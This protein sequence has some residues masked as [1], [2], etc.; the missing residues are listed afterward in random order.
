MQMP[1]D[2]WR[3]AH[4]RTRTGRN[5]MYMELQDGGV[6]GRHSLLQG[7]LH[8]RRSRPLGPC[9]DHCRQSR[10][11]KPLFPPNATT[12]KARATSR[13][14]AATSCKQRGTADQAP[15]FDHA[16]PRHRRRSRGQARRALR[17]R[18]LAKGRQVVL[19]VVETTG[20]VPARC[21]PTRSG[22]CTRSTPRRA[23]RGASTARTSTARRARPPPPSSRTTCVSSRSPPL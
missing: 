22:C 17:R 4:G 16:P 21:T 3:D 18:P 2:G 14:S 5:Y 8:C 13:P 7:L 11:Q 12:P 20:A 1:G 6:C 15:P 19:I 23:S 9:S 10:G